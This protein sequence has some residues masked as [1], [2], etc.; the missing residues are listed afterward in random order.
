MTRR[1]ITKC[2]ERSVSVFCDR[3][4]GL[5][6]NGLGSNDFHGVF[7][8][9][10]VGNSA[11]IFTLIPY[12]VLHFSRNGMMKARARDS[13]PET[14]PPDLGENLIITISYLYGFGSVVDK[15]YYY[16]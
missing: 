13:P 11:P 7:L 14:A 8:R 6:V 9:D 15:N 4:N 2:I 12:A 10:M 5:V 3:A 1:I 16:F